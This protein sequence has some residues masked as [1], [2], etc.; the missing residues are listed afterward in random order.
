MKIVGFKSNEGLRLGVVEGDQV[1]DLQAVDAD[2]PADLKD[3]LAAFEDHGDF[4][5]LIRLAG[6]LK[7]ATD[8]VA[9]PLVGG[10]L[11]R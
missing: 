9:E 11:V 5:L 6:L 8:Q 1:I 4:G 7:G 2:F 10:D 3:V